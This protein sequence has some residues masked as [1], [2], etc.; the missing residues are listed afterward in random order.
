M[1]INFNPGRLIAVST[2][3]IVANEAQDMI[4]KGTVVIGRK[5]KQR[6]GPRYEECSPYKVSL[7]T[8]YPTNDTKPDLFV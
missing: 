7:V 4:T 6:N 8:I 5:P 2:S 3:K 1:G